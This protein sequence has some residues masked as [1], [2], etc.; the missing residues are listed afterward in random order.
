M[1]D[2]LNHQ[3]CKAF[4]SKADHPFG[5]LN[6]VLSSDPAQLA[7]IRG[8]PVYAFPNSDEA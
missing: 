5:G 1:F 3:L 2:T 7:P 8:Q 4:P 6:I